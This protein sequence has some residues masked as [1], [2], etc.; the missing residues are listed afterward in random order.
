MLLAAFNCSLI[1]LCINPNHPERSSTM[2]PN[3]NDVWDNKTN[4][5]A[6]PNTH[7]NLSRKGDAPLPCV[8]VGMV[9]SVNP[10]NQS[11]YILTPVS[12]T[13]LAR[14]NTLVFT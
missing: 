6:N 2:V 5:H 14:V 7:D 12:P 10:N 13:I 4:H 1:G 3:P 11:L 8:G 9:R